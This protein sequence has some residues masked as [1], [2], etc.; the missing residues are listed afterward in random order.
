M[1]VFHEFEATSVNLR[2]M[3]ARLCASEFSI[4]FIRGLRD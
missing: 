4:F 2:R 3:D 1:D